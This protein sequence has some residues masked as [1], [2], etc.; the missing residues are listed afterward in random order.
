MD[1]ERKLSSFRDYYNG[2]RVHSPL[3]GQTPNEVSDDFKGQRADVHTYRWEPHCG[4][5]YQ[6]PVAA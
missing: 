6:L 5:L 1:L 2:S 4:E 3:G